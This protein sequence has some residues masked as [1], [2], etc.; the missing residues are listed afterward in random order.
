MK[1][2]IV[3][4][5]LLLIGLVELSAQNNLEKILDDLP[6]KSSVE[7]TYLMQQLADLGAP[8]IL[9]L[10]EKLVP[11]RSSENDDKER[12]ALSGLAK[13]VGKNPGTAAHQTVEEGFRNA[14]QANFDIEVDVFLLEQL[15]FFATSS[16]I[17]VLAEKIG[18]LCEPV[19]QVLTQ[20][21]TPEAL[22]AIISA[23]ENTQGYCQRVAT[24]AITSFESPKSINH[25]IELAKRSEDDH[26][27]LKAL[28]GLSRSTTKGAFEP[29]LA[30][31]ATDSDRGNDLLLTHTI[32][33]AQ[34]GNISNLQTVVT[35]LMS[36]G[37]LNQKREAIKLSAKHLGPGAQKN[38]IKT[39][40]KGPP[41]LA[42]LLTAALVSDISIPLDPYFKFI[43]KVDDNSKINLLSAATLRKYRPAAPIAKSYLTSS[44]PMVQMAALKTVSNLLGKE[45]LGDI[46]KVMNTTSNQRLLNAATEEFSRWIS[47]ENMDVLTN[48]LHQSSGQNKAALID[49]IAARKIV[50]LWPQIESLLESSN[51]QVRASAFASIPRLTGSASVTDL[52]ALVSIAQDD[53]EMAFIEQAFQ[54]KAKQAS[55]KN[56]IIDPL[57]SAFGNSNPKL[58]GRIFPA[59]GGEK[60][61]QYVVKHNQEALSSWKW[62]Q[63]IPHL[64]GLM[65]QN[66][67][68]QEVFDAILRLCNHADLPSD[69]K[70]LYLRKLM[71]LASSD[72]DRSRIIRPLS[73]TRQHTAFMYVRGLLKDEKLKLSAANALVRLALPAPGESLGL[74]GT[75][76]RAGLLQA[77][78]ILKDT[79]DAYTRAFLHNY[80]KVMPEEGGFTSIFNG[81]N[82]DGWQGL[83]ENPIARDTMFRT[84]LRRKQLEADAK[85]KDNWKVEDGKIVFFGEGYQNL[86]SV[87]SYRDFELIVDWKI[88]KGGDSGIYLRGSPQV[89]IWDTALVEQGAQVGS[90]GLYNNQEHESKPLAVADNAVG[91]W[92][93]FRIIMI[94]DKV[95]V[96]L[97]GILVTDNTVLENY[98]D[99]TMPIFR[100]GPIELQAHGTNLQ[101]RDIYIRELEGAPELSEIEK[102]M[103]FV[104]LFNGI[105]LDGWIGNKTDYIV[106]NG[107]IV[108][109]PHGG[110]GSGNL[111]TEKE[112]DDF[113]FSFEFKLTPGANNGLGIHAPLEGNAAYLGK[114]IQILDNTSPIYADLKDYQY[115][116][117]VYGILPAR[118]GALKPV[119]EWNS[120]EVTVK[121]NQIRVVL[122]GQ[123]ILA[124]NLDTVTRNGTLDGREHPGLKKLKGHIGFLGHGSEVRFRNIRIR[125]DK[126]D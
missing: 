125:E 43:K 77:D 33:Q 93:T 114:E 81:K 97:N 123:R 60:A 113:T 44:D 26:I 10:S 90:G 71:P 72:E 121:G 45:S 8:A 96:Y 18:L 115:H 99:R 30:F 74:V 75:D 98:W 126:K 47:K 105:N 61:L 12:Y 83:V 82:L 108:I 57:I 46:Q 111:Y 112:Y 4:A 119:G 91:D 79:E 122:N 67:H 107:E 87:K 35:H 13:Y 31:A 42:N 2:L 38:L 95:T 85:L 22:D 40:K 27:K 48:A 20:I 24:K 1:Q 32:K 65:E 62:P 73:N 11:P 110:G 63:A 41:E 19:I 89:Q 28:Q 68:S 36:T 53:Q 88:T 9:S 117:S 5:T 58:L 69:Q 76:V 66:S 120:Q 14:L 51:A 23:S 3:L 7:L 78:T 109:Y 106:E 55:D 104:Q 59:I 49:L 80:L 6:A 50:S 100:E 94:Q 54:L 37:T 84:D 102:N 101:F 92:N 116:G 124:D 56:T 118:K 39:L 29:L 103:G 52:M 86:C 17:D 34:T 70:V 64:F 21:G 25:I 15:Q 16:S